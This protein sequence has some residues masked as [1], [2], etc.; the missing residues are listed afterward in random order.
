MVPVALQCWVP[1]GADDQGEHQKV[2]RWRQNMGMAIEQ[3]EDI[4]K[5]RIFYLMDFDDS[6]IGR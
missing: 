6:N 2:R 1:P 4:E 5:D 3:M